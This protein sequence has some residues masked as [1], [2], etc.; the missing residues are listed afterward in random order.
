MKTAQHP[1]QAVKSLLLESVSDSDDS[2][3]A[4]CLAGRYL[5][6]L[7]GQEHPADLVHRAVSLPPYDPE[8][9]RKLAGL[10]AK[11]CE[12]R[13]Q[14]LEEA[15]EVS[16]QRI[17]GSVEVVDVGTSHSALLDDETYVFNLLLFASYL[18]AVESLFRALMRFHEVG[19]RL[20]ALLSGSGRAGRQLRQALTYQ[21]VDDTLEDFW[22]ALIRQGQDRIGLLDIERK[23]DLLDAW[24]GLLWIPP[25]A[26]EREAGKTLSVDRAARGLRALHDAT[27]HSA[28]GFLILRHAVRQLS[29]AYPRSP[30]FWSERLSSQLEE[31]PELLREVIFDQWPLL[32]IAGIE[33]AAPEMPEDAM[34][35]WRALSADEQSKIEKAATGAESDTWKS[36]WQKELYFLQPRGGLPGQQWVAGLRKIRAAFEDRF[37]ALA[38]GS[39]GR[40]MEDLAEPE[41]SA[42]PTVRHTE[43]PKRVDRVAAYERVSKVLGEV[44]QL[45]R[46][47]RQ[48]KARRY[49]GDLVSLQRRAQTPAELIVKTL[50]NAAASAHKLAQPE[51]AEELYNQAISLAVDDPVPENGLAVVLKAQG[52]FDDAEQLY[53]QTTARF[54]DNVVAQTGLAEVLKAQG[55]FDD[56]EHLYRQ[57]TARF[58]DDVVAQTGLAE[59]LKAQGRFDQA[60]QLYRQTTARFPDNVVAQNGLAEV[61]KAQGRFD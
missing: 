35:I 52:R 61:L 1:L 42:G 25:S 13:A 24:K 3:L 8:L 56:A 51:W 59:V 49:L 44:D 40:S 30:E 9:P 32:A 21:Q 58:P 26:A 37:P 41:Q 23:T 11:L 54:P 28:D 57:T 22:S 20:G 45:L 36:L 39:E 43:R 55:R 6:A 15:L 2:R 5:P 50:C 60:E 53:R 19:L 10:T 29:E 38:T 12:N 31:W 16:N 47:G 34:E 18:P 7:G 14:A 27:V 48:A 4:E 17:V 46:Q 33:D